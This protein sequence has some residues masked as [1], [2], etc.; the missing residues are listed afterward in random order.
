[1]GLKE[2]IVQAFENAATAPPKR[3]AKTLTEA[4]FLTTSHRPPAASWLKCGADFDGLV[5][6][7]DSQ[8]TA[9]DKIAAK[10]DIDQR[11]AIRYWKKYTAAPGDDY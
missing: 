8:T 4:L 5:D 3:R 1:M 6:D 2:H 9:A 10:Y 11:S 7:G